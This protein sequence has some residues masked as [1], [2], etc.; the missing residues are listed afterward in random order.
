M[1]RVF[2]KRRM[3]GIAIVTFVIVLVLTGFGIAHF[4][5]KA[6]P[7]IPYNNEGISPDNNTAV[8]HFDGSSAS[9]VHRGWL[10]KNGS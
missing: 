10:L 7:L 5:V 9:L 6:A 3:F 1:Q 4:M 2:A 8:G